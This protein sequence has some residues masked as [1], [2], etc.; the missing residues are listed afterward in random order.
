MLS[1]GLTAAHDGACSGSAGAPRA[2]ANR[3]G[4][5]ARRTQPGVPWAGSG[6]AA[7]ARRLQQ[8]AGR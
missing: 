7:R 6:H 1:A 4:A 5:L 2:P 8:L 3:G